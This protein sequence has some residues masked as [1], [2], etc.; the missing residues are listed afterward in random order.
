MSRSGYTD[1]MDDDLAMGRWRAQV[2]SAIR[3][4]RGQHMLADLLQALDSMPEKALIIGDLK[5][6]Q[7]E[8]C[9][10][11]ALGVARGMDLARIDPEDPEQ[12]AA[13]FDIAH[14]LAAEIAYVNDEYFEDQWDDSVKRYVPLS[15]EKRWAGVR[16][17]V[18]A[19]IINVSE[20]AV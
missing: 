1:D 13:A 18:A 12:V 17:W 10:L 7:G 2:A 20:V 15:P 9:A 4:K 14:Q 16:K 11:G 19:Q 8:V 6:E 5:T 3:G